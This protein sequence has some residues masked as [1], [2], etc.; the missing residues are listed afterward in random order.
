MGDKRKRKG[1]RRGG[2]EAD[3]NLHF[4]VCT[5]GVPPCFAFDDIYGGCATLNSLSRG[6]MLSS[7][8]SF[9]DLLASIESTVKIKV[10]NKQG[11]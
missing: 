8:S 10:V 2:K 1:E 4:M 6:C 3:L 5:E 11:P 7:V 9:R